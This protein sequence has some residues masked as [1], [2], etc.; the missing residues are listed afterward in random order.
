SLR[1]PAPTKHG[2]QG[3]D[4]SQIVEPSNVPRSK[5]RLGH[6]VTSGCS[7]RKSLRVSVMTHS[8]SYEDT[9][10]FRRTAWAWDLRAGSI[11]PYR[12]R[13]RARSSLPTGAAWLGRDRP[14][15][16]LWPCLYELL[17]DRE[18]ARADGIV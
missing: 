4:T 2:S 14:S 12:W 17:H 9:R 5:A 13:F 15:Y 10:R 8:Q 11:R 6:D 1:P 16:L 7:A 18:R 3:T